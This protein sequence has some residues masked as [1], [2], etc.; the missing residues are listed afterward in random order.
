MATE[1]QVIDWGTP[2]CCECGGP[3]SYGAGARCRKCYLD[4]A[5]QK[6]EGTPY[7]VLLKTLE[8]IERTGGGIVLTPYGWTLR[9]NCVSLFERP[10]L[11]Y[12]AT[13]NGSG[14]TN[15]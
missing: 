8:E 9:E 4:N 14:A 11:L 5:K 10:D 7:G 15:D 1:K 13:S 3:K 2:I 6:R 12:R